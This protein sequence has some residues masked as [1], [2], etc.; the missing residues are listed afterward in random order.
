MA[1]ES[2]VQ[3]NLPA[4][5]GKGA[6]EKGRKVPRRC[7]TS[8]KSFPMLQCREK[9]LHQLQGVSFAIPN[10]AVDTSTWNSVHRMV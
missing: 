1:L 7:P 2:E 3:G 5:F 10:S 8:S 9:P 6:S 4:S